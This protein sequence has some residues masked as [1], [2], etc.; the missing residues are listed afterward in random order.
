MN[1]L[2]SSEVGLIDLAE[3]TPSEYELDGSLNCGILIR[4]PSP[5]CQVSV[6]NV[7]SFW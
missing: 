5:G 2:L 3:Y 6:P 1:P 7:V 4:I